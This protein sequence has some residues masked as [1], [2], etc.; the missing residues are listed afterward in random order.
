MSKARDLSALLGGGSTGVPTFGGTGAICIPNGTAA[1]RP[2]PGFGML[3]YNS[4]SGL[5]ENYNSVG[6]QGIDSPPVVSNMTGVINADTSS[7]IIITG[8]NFKSGAVISIEG[9]GVSNTPRSLTTS[10]VNSSTLSANTNA[11]AINFV[12]G[13]AYSV[14]VTNPS[15]L[16]STLADVGYIDRDPLWSTSAGTLATINDAFGSYSSIA[17]LSAADPEGSPIVYAVDS[18]SLPGNVTLNSSTGVLSGDPTNVTSNT[19]YSFVVSASSNGQVCQS[20]VQHH[21]EQSA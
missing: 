4:D 17:T 13:A 20:F 21:C 8:S 6:W 5:V 15:G 11:S 19:T 7:T 9:A 18:G 3:R 1:Q 10:F 14:K 2:T 16:S 12:G